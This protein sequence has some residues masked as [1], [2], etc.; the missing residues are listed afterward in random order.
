MTAAHPTPKDREVS[1]LLDIV[2]SLA[3]DDTAPTADM[4]PLSV[5][6][7]TLGVVTDAKDDADVIKAALAG[8]LAWIASHHWPEVSSEI[9]TITGEVLQ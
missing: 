4:R 9:R 1:R 2:L 6:V 7:N 8:A 5:I 3:A